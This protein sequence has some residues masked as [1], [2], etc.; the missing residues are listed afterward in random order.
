MENTSPSERY[1]HFKWVKNKQIV[2]SGAFGEGKSSGTCVYCM[3][4]ITSASKQ[5]LRFWTCPSFPK[6]TSKKPMKGCL[7]SSLCLN[8]YSISVLASMVGGF[9]VLVAVLVCAGVMRKGVWAIS[10]GTTDLCGQLQH[11]AFCL[12]TWR[13]SCS[14]GTNP[15]MLINS[16]FIILLCVPYSVQ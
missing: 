1:L 14:V 2:F 9:A 7:K 12:R 16:V 8:K 13:S 4:G 15:G 6:V 3:D 10:E 11:G 5:W